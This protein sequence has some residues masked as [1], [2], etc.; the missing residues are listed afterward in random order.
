MWRQF[1]NYL[2]KMSDDFKQ[3]GLKTI[4]FQFLAFS[5][6]SDIQITVIAYKRKFLK[7]YLMKINFIKKNLYYM[8]T[9]GN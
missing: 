6:K 4:R 7:L 1:D 2:H 9:S 5:F 8:H 3:F